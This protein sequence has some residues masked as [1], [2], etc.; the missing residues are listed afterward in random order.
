MP[1]WG[2]YLSFAMATL[3]TGLLMGLVSYTLII[4]SLYYCITTKPLINTKHNFYVTQMLLKGSE[5]VENVIV[6]RKM[7]NR[8]SLT[9]C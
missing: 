8:L 7:P 6:L 2:S 9:A 5:H 1:V 4:I 3:V